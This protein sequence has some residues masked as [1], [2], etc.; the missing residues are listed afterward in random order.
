QLRRL[1]LLVRAGPGA[2]RDLRRLRAVESP[3]APPATGRLA[4]GPVLGRRLRDLH[5]DRADL[6]RRAVRLRLQRLTVLLAQ[7]DP[8]DR[9]DAVLPPRRLRQPQPGTAG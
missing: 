6:L 8:G 1:L 7:P 2:R 3:T 4:A 5:G 9:R